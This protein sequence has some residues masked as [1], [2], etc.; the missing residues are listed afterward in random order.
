MPQLYTQSLPSPLGVLHLYARGEALTGLHFTAPSRAPWTE[1][2]PRFDHPVLAQ[3]ARELTEYF[4]SGRHEFATPLGPAGTPFQLEVWQALGSIPFG[5]QRSY[6]WLA[7]QCG[8]PLACRAAGAACGRNPLAIFIPC[9]RALGAR[10]QLTG[11]AGGIE[12][13]RWLLQHEGWRG[14]E[15]SLFAAL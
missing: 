1:A 11:F 12:A 5:E 15:S 4:A 3:A 6:N 9:H 10:G 2:R 14:R 8:N 13:K 7:A